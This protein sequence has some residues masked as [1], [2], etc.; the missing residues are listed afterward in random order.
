MKNLGQGDDIRGFGPFLFFK[1]N[2]FPH[3]AHIISWDGIAKSRHTLGEIVAEI[4]PKE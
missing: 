1:N 4:H 2:N 3:L